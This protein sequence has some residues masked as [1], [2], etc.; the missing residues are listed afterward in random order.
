[1]QLSRRLSA[2]AELITEGNR[3]ADI[4][5]DH[6][7]LPVWLCLEGKIPG[8]LAM[9][10]RSGPLSSA[11]EHIESNGLE[12]RIETRLSDGLRE[13]LPGE[14]DTVVIAGMGGPLMERILS[15][16]MEVLT[17][18]K[19]LVLQP[20]SDLPHFRRFLME[21]GFRIVGERAVLEEGKYYFPMRV[22][23]DHT[24]AGLAPVPKELWT[25]VEISFGRQL[26][27]EKDPVL[28]QYLHWRKG[29]CED[30]LR[31]LGDACGEKTGKRYDEVKEEELRIEAALAYYEV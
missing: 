29:I 30:I 18:V 26:L 25:E 10:V 19:E 2:I 5:C 23:P 12:D 20:Q 22:I 9:D 7:Y 31:Q 1:M 21:N 6:G 13:L 3:I 17:S 15:E 4:G 8:A 28:L 11:R 14:A 27:R 16:G 24:T